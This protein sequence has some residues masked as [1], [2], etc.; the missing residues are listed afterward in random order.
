M[1][2]DETTTL[3]TLA[4]RQPLVDRDGHAYLIEGFYAADAAQVLFET[5]LKELVWES[6]EIVVFGKR[7]PVPRLVCWYGD[8]E[9]VYRYS[10][11]EHEPLAW[12][13]SLQTIRERVTSTCNTAFNSVLG[14][15]YRD[16]ND[17]MGWHADNEP[18]LGPEPSIASLSL[19]ATRLFKLCHNR[20]KETVDIGLESGSL[21]V[22]SGS[23][24]SHWRHSVPKTQRAVGPRINLTFRR[25]LQ[26]WQSA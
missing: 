24:Q 4:N 19:G 16:G 18:E 12:T 9:A 25:I 1:A 22:M 5:L 10:G 3:P 17:S 26:A 7:V 6:E 13:P 8:A 15:L 20:S 14:N 2:T 23:L 11:V 21:L